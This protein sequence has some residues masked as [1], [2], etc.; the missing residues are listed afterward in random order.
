MRKQYF[1]DKTLRAC[2]ILMLASVIAGTLSA[3]GPSDFG[4]GSSN[5]EIITP[6]TPDQAGDF[7]DQIETE[8]MARNA[9]AAIVFRTGRPRS[10]LPDGI[11]YTHGGFWIL[12]DVRL[13]DGSQGKAYAVYNLYHGEG[14][15]ILTSFL[16]QDWPAD[17]AMGTAVEDVGVLIP[18]AMLQEK[19]RKVVR[20]PDY[21]QLHVTD[22]SL[23]SNPFNAQYQ[24]CNEFMLDVIASQIWADPIR[25]PLDYGAIKAKLKASFAATTIKPGLLMR[26]LGPQLDPRLRINDHAGGKIQTVTYESLGD[27]LESQ[28]HLDARFKI[29]RKPAPAVTG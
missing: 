24:N 1:G 18:D 14:D 6:L 21:A 23:I 17:F 9:Q 8:L 3:C 20:S 26:F 29:I 2:A 4:G 22:Y 27:F 25:G 28:K 10:K 16:H 12:S 7:A 5:H 11:S 19:L 15:K 13:S